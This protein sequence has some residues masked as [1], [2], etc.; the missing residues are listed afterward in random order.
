M[1]P[2]IRNLLT[3]TIIP[4]RRL[5]VEEDNVVGL[6]GGFK[7]LLANAKLEL[8][9]GKT[10]R[11]VGIDNHDQALCSTSYFKSTGG[12][13]KDMLGHAEIVWAMWTRIIGIGPYL[14]ERCLLTLSFMEFVRDEATA[15]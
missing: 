6:E 3:G 9:V 13:Y 12:G 1:Y 7:E 8:V 14:D 11:I 4:T 5:V 10:F 2:G 15:S